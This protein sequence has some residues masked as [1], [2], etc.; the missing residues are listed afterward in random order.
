MTSERIRV[1]QRS[2]LFIAFGLV[3]Y[4]VAL[5][6]CF[7]YH[8]AR[9]MAVAVAA[10]NGY[11]LDIGSVGASFPFGILFED[12]R[13]R[14]RSAMPGGKPIQARFESARLALL[15]VFFSRGKAFDLALEGLGGHIELHVKAEKRGPFEFELRARDINMARLPGVR[16]AF[17]LPLGGSLGIAARLESTSGR[18]ADAKGELSLK[19][20]SCAVGDGRTPIKIPGNNPF[21]AAGLTLPR[22]RLGDV[23]GRA[24][25]DKGTIKLQGVQ[26]KSM[27]A[28]LTLE[29]EIALHDPIAYSTMNLYCRFKLG[30]GLLKASPAIASVLQMAAAPGHRPDGFYGVRLGGTFSSP[31]SMFSPTASLGSGVPATGRPGGRPGIMP[32]LPPTASS[33]TAS[34]AAP[35]PPP[36]SAPPAIEMEPLPSPQPPPSPPP[37]APPP[38]PSP[39][40]ESVGAAPPVRGVPASGALIESARGMLLRGVAGPGASRAGGGAPGANSPSPEAMGAAP[41]PGPPP[42]PPAAAPAPAATG[43]EPASADDQT[44]Q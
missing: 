17:N 21:L 33:N 13:V 11:D 24:V 8:R 42:S 41:A 18:F 37:A 44:V 6:F 9:E 32:V 1:V 36:T 43:Q 28:E 31:I 23:A 5:M 30:E 4:V 15:P 29:G 26:G 3:A 19:C 25:V 20:G 12:I 35:S 7:P 16:E 38:P 2:A 39:P 34:I 40:P 22:V 27:D 14:S 10:R